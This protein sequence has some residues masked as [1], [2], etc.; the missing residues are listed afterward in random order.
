[1][2]ECRSDFNNAGLLLCPI[3]NAQI[4]LRSLA[5]NEELQCSR[6]S[7][8]ALRGS[9]AASLQ[10]ALALSIAGLILV[11]LANSYPIMIFDVA[12]NTQENRIIT[13]VFKLYDQGYW[14]ISVLVFFSAIAA[15]FLY[16]SS[17]L[18]VTVSCCLRKKFPF[19]R[20]LTEIVEFFNAWN[21]VPVFA[22]ACI[23]AVVKLKMLGNVHWRPGMLWI[24]LLSVCSIALAQAFDKDLVEERL[25]GVK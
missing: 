7:H 14:P 25:E 15:P 9:R 6:C 21:L 10:P 23:A 4:R 1:M 24:I 22:I 5:T 12:G 2:K 19:L 18:Y 16:L 20:E 13:G 3:C 17:V 8:V 11:I